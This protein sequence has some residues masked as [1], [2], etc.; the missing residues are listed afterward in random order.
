MTP[1]QGVA[2]LCLILVRINVDRNQLS[3]IFKQRNF[4]RIEY[5]SHVGFVDT[6]KRNQ[7]F[8]ELLSQFLFADIQWRTHAN[9][10]CSR[11]NDSGLLK[12]CMWTGGF[13]HVIHQQRFAA[14]SR[15]TRVS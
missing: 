2:K 3:L 5:E 1:L 14:T 9:L 13:N 7:F 12:A 8:A 6:V 4:E 10:Q 15:L 11:T